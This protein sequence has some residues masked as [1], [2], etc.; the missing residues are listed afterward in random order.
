[1][2]VEFAGFDTKGNY[3]RSGEIVEISNPTTVDINSIA[4]PGFDASGRQVRTAGKGRK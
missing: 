1:M 2:V 4:L 3:R